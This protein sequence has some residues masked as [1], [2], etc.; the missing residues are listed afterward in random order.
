MKGLAW[1][2]NNNKVLA[3]YDCYIGPSWSWAAYNGSAAMLDHA[4][5]LWED[6]AIA[7]A[8]HTEMRSKSN[9]Y[10]EVKT[11]WIQVHGPVIRLAP[12]S[13]YTQET[14][15]GSRKAKDD[16][17]SRT[18]CRVYTPYSESGHGVGLVLDHPQGNI[19][20]VL[21][22]WSPH[23]IILTGVKDENSVSLDTQ[24]ERVFSAWSLV[25]GLAIKKST[26]AGNTDKWERI[27]WTQ[28]RGE[29]SRKIIEAEDNW[30][31]VTLV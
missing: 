27:G 14:G 15:E 10:G 7:K 28:I 9:P 13:T 11:A 21:R 25:W 3:P 6:V 24:G 22:S 12:L 26:N 1:L 5:V 23:V 8:W 18:C 30:K 4:A 17:S 2:G 20:E 31:T 19:S 29:E 16:I